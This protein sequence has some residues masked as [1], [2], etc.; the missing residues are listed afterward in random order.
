MKNIFLTLSLLALLPQLSRAEDFGLNR[1]GASAFAEAGQGVPEPLAAVAAQDRAA[2]PAAPAALKDWTVM[3]FLN[4]KN[5]LERFGMQDINEMETV[6]SS[7]R[8]NVVVQMGRMAGYDSSDGNWT[9]VRRYYVTKDSNQARIASRLVQDLGRLNMGD[10]DELRNFIVWAK[11]QYPARRYAVIVWNHGNGW[12]RGNPA[13]YEGSS[14]G[15]S[16]DDETGNNID[17]PQLGRALSDAGGVDLLASDACLMQMAEV[18]YEVKAAA[19]YM[20]G[21]EETEPGAGYDYAKVL[22][23][24]VK[25]PSMNTAAFGRIIVD[26]YWTSNLIGFRLA[27]HSLLDLSRAPAL[28]RSMDAFARAAMA[29][30][31]KAVLQRARDEVQSYAIAQNKDLRHF[32]RLVEG[33]AA[34]AALKTAARALGSSIEGGIVLHDRSSVLPRSN[35]NGI[36]AYIPNLRVDGDFAALALARD[37]QWDE[38]LGWLNR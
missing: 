20:V 31:D 32:A 22:G 13:A 6:G 29:S 18:A 23:P 5:D 8:V 35:S 36:A 12:L 19:K 14:K 1:L 30:A 4:A 33:R 9:G 34:S 27:T 37:T 21:S 28:A 26:A 7:D 2:A 3:V 11:R 25:Q 17:T 38:F 24:L 10:A 16:F 15:I